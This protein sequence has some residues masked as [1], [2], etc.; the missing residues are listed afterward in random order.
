[1]G[2]WIEIVVSALI[3]N[4]FCVA[5]LVGAWIEILGG[6]WI[7]GIVILSHP[8]WVRGLKSCWS[9]LFPIS[10]PSHPLWVRGLKSTGYGE[11][12]FDDMSHP[13]WV[14][15]LKS[16]SHTTYVRIVGRTPC[17]CVDWNYQKNT[18][19]P[20]QHK[21]HPLWVRGLKSCLNVNRTWLLLCLAG[22]LF[23]FNR[24]YY[25]ISKYIL[26]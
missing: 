15:G 16:L 9:R 2:A 17:G 12:C 8:L 21:S 26:Y 10:F 6:E 20:T 3:C 4:I 5:P 14:R 11:A 13:L 24:M 18:Y 7:L 1:M 23:K 25:H 19:I 22:V